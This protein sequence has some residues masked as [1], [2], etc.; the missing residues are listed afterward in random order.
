MI[1]STG[2]ST[3]EEI[4]DVVSSFDKNNISI[5]SCT[6]T[7]PTANEDMNLNKIKT[8][9]AK[10]PTI[11]IGYSGHEQGILPTLIAVAFG[12]AIIERHITVS[13]EI[14]GSDQQASLEPLELKELVEKIND[15]KLMLGNGN[16]KMLDS[17]KSIKEK[18][19]RY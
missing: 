9:M 2:M 10:Y 13:R 19:R 5:L 16:I 12:A 14:W 17:E 18:L 6:S 15:V 11:P 7:Y 8:L 4:D 1:I 3:E